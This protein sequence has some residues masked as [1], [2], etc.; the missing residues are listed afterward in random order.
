[1]KGVRLQQELSAKQASLAEAE[2]ELRGRIAALEER[3]ARLAAAEEMLQRREAESTTPAAA[4]DQPGAAQRG[5]EHGPLQPRKLPRLGDQLPDFSA[6]EWTAAAVR[7]RRGSLAQ[8]LKFSRLA[9][10][11]LAAAPQQRQAAGDAA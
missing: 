7:Q 8:R 9:L 1:M 11:R 10:E 4:A 3:D 5:V 6:D 2:L